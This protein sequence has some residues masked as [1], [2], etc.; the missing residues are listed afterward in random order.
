MCHYSERKDDV[1]RVVWDASHEISAVVK[2][3]RKSSVKLNIVSLFYN[4]PQGTFLFYRHAKRKT[5]I[6]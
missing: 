6:K 4:L 2:K 3:E 1:I 5:L